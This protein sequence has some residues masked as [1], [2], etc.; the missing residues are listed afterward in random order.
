MQLITYAGFDSPQIAPPVFQ[1]LARD[2]QQGLGTLGQ[3]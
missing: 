2:W 1:S 3:G